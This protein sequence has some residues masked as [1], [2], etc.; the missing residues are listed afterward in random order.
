MHKFVDIPD[1]E[2]FSFAKI[3]HLSGV[4]YQEA[5]LK[6]LIITQVLLVLGNIQGHSETCVFFTQHNATDLNFF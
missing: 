6:S 1:C 2:H 5:D 4:E 3:I